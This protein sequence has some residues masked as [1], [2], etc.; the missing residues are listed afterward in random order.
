[1]ELTPTLL[2]TIAI[3]TLSVGF[4]ILSLVNR[5]RRIDRSGT[6]LIERMMS[7][8]E[9]MMS[10]ITSISERIGYLERNTNTDQ[11]NLLT[12]RLNLLTGQMNTLK[13]SAMLHLEVDADAP[14][15]DTL[16]RVGQ[17]EN[18]AF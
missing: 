1:M 13:E 15:A 2:A 11:L 9:H 4:S 12:N 5:R 14:E 18:N 7:Q 16:K 6:E 8:I 10:Q 3:A 17:L